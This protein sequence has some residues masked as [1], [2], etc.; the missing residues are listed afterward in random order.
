MLDSRPSRTA[1]AVAGLRALHQ[2]VDRPIV[3]N[4]P[5]AA[6]VISE[7]ARVLL[8]ERLGDARR[9]ARLRASV[10]ARSRTAE[11]TLAEAVTRGVRQYVLLGAGLDT[12]GCSRA[13]AFQ[14]GPS[15]GL[16][17]FEVD[18][19]ATQ[20]W[21]LECLEAAGLSVPSHLHF[22]PIDFERQ[23]LRLTLQQAGFRFDEPAVFALLGVAIYI[24][25]DALLQTL[26]VPGSMQPG[27]ATLVFDYAEP[28]EGAPPAIRAAYTA[29]G[30]RAAAEG[31]PWRTTFHPADLADALHSLGFRTID[32]RDSARMKA[33]LFE[34]R[35]DGLAPGPLSHVVV[36]R[37]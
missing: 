15:G 30:E 8:T 2:Q 29:M 27:F 21:K 24:E 36:A 12:F 17:V 1:L 6:R 4:D 31:E 19:P 25:R 37:N 26:A 23:D 9:S 11:D 20:A 28:F 13:N 22:V 18:H 34:N 16:D 14:N 33:D 10:V 5:V 3:F 35:E 32:D 7:P